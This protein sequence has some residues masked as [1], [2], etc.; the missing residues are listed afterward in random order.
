MDTESVT[1]EAMMLP[2]PQRTKLIEDLLRSLNPAEQVSIDESWL[3]ESNRRYA[4]YKKGNVV[5]VDGEQGLAEI[6]R[7]LRG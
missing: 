4:E 1:K 3:A 2:V 7:E 5:A 6:T